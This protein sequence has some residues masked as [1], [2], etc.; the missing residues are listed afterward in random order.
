MGARRYIIGWVHIAALA[1]AFLAATPAMADEETENRLRAALRDAT[2]QL[3][4]VQEQNA[5]LQ[6]K[7][8]AQSAAPPP[9]PVKVEKSGISKAAYDKA[10][11]TLTHRI[12]D[13][14]QAAAKW[15]AAYDQAMESAHG[16][17]AEQQKTIAELTGFKDR[18][19]V[20]ETKNAKL[21]EIGNELLDRYRNI[22]FG[23]TLA[24]REPFIGTKRVEL[25]TLA[26]DYRDKLS[27]NKVKP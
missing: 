5:E 7:V 27:D 2:A 15:K 23:D 12:A 21:F 9:A 4:V 24:A 16:R 14:D 18:T 17:E 10:V 1:A 25:E 8:A 11:S 13:S 20:C 22:D 3:R 19:Q 6:T 26:Q